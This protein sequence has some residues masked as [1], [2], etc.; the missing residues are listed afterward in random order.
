MHTIRN[1]PCTNKSTYEDTILSNKME[2]KQI[3]QLAYCEQVISDKRVMV[4]SDDD[5]KSKDSDG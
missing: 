3:N 4:N 2:N 5:D 1:G